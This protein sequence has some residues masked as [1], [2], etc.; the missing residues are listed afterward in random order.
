MSSFLCTLES[1][2]RESAWAL[3]SCR[4]VA[5]LKPDQGSMKTKGNPRVGSSKSIRLEHYIRKRCARQ[6]DRNHLR[7][8]GG[9]YGCTVEGQRRKRRRR[10]INQPDRLSQM[11]ITERSENGKDE[12]TN[13]N[14]EMHAYRYNYFS[15]YHEE[16]QG[17]TFEKLSPKEWLPY[18]F[19]P[20]PSL[21]SPA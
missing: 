5:T 16:N 3:F 13:F 17:R 7:L 14:E 15:S 21:F 4:F 12:G 19:P 20:P 8:R 2:G 9:N 10:G 11:V 18:P 6:T 1:D